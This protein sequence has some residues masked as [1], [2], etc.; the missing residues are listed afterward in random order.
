MKVPCPNCQRPAW[1]YCIV[2]GRC[3]NCRAEAA[4]EAAPEFALTLDDIRDERSRRLAACDWTQLPDVP[5][6]TRLLWQNYRQ[7]LRDLPLD[8]EDP[9][10]VP[11]PDPPG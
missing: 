9:E 6:E 10:K 2:D 5:E 11:W 7:A 4:R 8:I 3:D 1:V